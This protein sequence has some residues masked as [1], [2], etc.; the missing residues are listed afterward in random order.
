MDRRDL[1]AALVLTELGIPLDSLNAFDVRRAFQKA[2]Y[3]LQEGRT[4]WQ[5]GFA[6]NLYIRGPYSP[7]LAD[8]A[9]RLLREREGTIEAQ[10]AELAHRC[11]QDIRFL[12]ELFPDPQTGSLDADL[13][14][15]AATIHFL[16]SR[17]FAHLPDDESRMGQTRA[18]INQR[19]SQLAARFDEARGKL[20]QLHMVSS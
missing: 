13:L 9:Y 4:R 7:D 15:L 19:K 16:L 8:S 14:E 1:G 5:F 18:W 17:T 11:R 6:F 20:C 3:L 12:R 10:Q 2:I